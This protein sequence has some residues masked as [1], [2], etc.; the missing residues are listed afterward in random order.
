MTGKKKNLKLKCMWI[1]SE[2]NF[3]MM[4]NTVCVG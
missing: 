2:S 1:S 3:G 4:K